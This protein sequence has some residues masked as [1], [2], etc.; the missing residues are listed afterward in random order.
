[1]ACIRCFLGY[2]PEPGS[3]RRRR[4]M[5]RASHRF[6]KHES[7]RLIVCRVPDQAGVREPAV[8]HPREA[9]KNSLIPGGM[10]LVHHARI[11][12]PS[13]EG[14]PVKVSG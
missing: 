11:R 10:Q 2:D 5:R 12:R 1:M 13:E 6:W 8:R 4:E 7:F 14:G 9:A 3:W